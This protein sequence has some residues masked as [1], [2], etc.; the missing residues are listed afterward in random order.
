MNLWQVYD[1]HPNLTVWL[2]MVAAVV[3]I[4][5][6]IWLAWLIAF[7]RID[8]V[9]AKQR[10]PRK[11]AEFN[12]AFQRPLARPRGGGERSGGAD[13]PARAGRG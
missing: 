8:W 11:D 6:A 12:Q 2:I 1:A 13:R 10:R 5:V 4:F 9:H 7:L 3:G